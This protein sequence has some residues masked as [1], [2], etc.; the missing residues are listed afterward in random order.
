ME[1]VTIKQNLLS[2]NAFAEEHEKY[3]EQ[4]KREMER[5]R[6]EEEQRKREENKEELER[7]VNVTF[8]ALLTHALIV[9]FW[10]QQ[11]PLEL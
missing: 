11:D 7:L 2:E 6:L 1:G 4:M 10:Y 9:D 3:A 8:S 5:R